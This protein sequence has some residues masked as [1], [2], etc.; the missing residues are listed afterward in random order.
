[1]RQKRVSSLQTALLV[2]LGLLGILALEISHID[3]AQG[4]GKRIGD[5]NCDGKVNSIDAF[6]ILQISAALKNTLPCIQW[7]DVN[8]D[9][10]INSIDAALILQFHAGLIKELQPPKRTPTESPTQRKQPTPTRTFTQTFTSTPTQTPTETPTRTNPPSSTPTNTR[11]ATPTRTYAPTNTPFSTLTPTQT[12]TP[13]P[14]N[15]ITPTGTRTP[16]QTP[17]KIP[18]STPTLT[19]TKTQ[20][21]TRTLTPTATQTPNQTM[22]VFLIA[23]PPA[24]F[25][26]LNGVDLEAVV[27][28][29]ATGTITFRFDCTSNGTWEREVVTD[30]VIFR[31]ENLCDYQNP[32]NYSAKVRVERGELQIEGTSQI[33]VLSSSF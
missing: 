12:N 16:T 11:T 32:G 15:T 14:T 31:S 22:K 8:Q 28:G 18:T 30:S 20:T 23:K 33:V 2:L 21:P 6:F 19:H 4:T 1:M 7:T 25:A 27:S 17:T 29:T 9:T 13:T 5:V 3:F 26:P 24:G 10:I